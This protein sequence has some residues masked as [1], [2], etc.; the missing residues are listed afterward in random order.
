MIYKIENEII[1]AEINSLGAELWTLKDIRRETE[2]LWYGDEKYWDYRACS[3]FPVCA[4]VKNNTITINGTDYHMPMH[5]FLR[6]YEHVVI[7]HSKTMIRFRFES[8]EETL[9]MYPFTFCVDT[10]FELKEN[11][12]IHSFEVVNTNQCVM[13]F[14]IGYHPGFLCP[15]DDKHSYTDYM[16]KFEKKEDL[17]NLSSANRPPEKRKPDLFD[18][19]TIDICDNVFI[20]VMSYENLKS[21][22][23]QLEEKDSGRA[24][25]V[26]FGNCTTLNLWSVAKDLPFVCIEP[27]YAH[28]ENG[29]AYGEFKNKKGLVHLD[30]KETF[31]CYITI[32]II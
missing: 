13:P 23:I 31:K 28:F 20:P 11:E 2:H 7:E 26:N 9:K 14:S 22:W 8:N 5:G 15:F 16:L 21:K 12:L 17:I 27:W 24:I 25:R 30:A 19:D 6:L 18:C 1:S 10:I 29:I 3:L 32:S 4:N